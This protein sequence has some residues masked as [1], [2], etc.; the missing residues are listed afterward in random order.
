MSHLGFCIS[1]SLFPRQGFFPYALLPVELCPKSGVSWRARM[2]SKPRL[3][4]KTSCQTASLF[5][6][7]TRC[8]L[9]CAG[10]ALESHGE[11]G[12][13]LTKERK[14][15]VSFPLWFLCFSSSLLQLIGFFPP[16]QWYS[17]C[18][19]VSKP[20]CRTDTKN[21]PPRRKLWAAFQLA[22]FGYTELAL[23]QNFIKK[24]FR[25]ARRKKEPSCVVEFQHWGFVIKSSV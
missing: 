1:F 17:G 12:M 11:Y 13:A 21:K 9:V 15:S 20:W 19:E 25:K 18:I 16:S 22:H 2:G 7:G 8:Q 24:A 4:F 6:Q 3:S 14:P 5:L 10:P 23:S